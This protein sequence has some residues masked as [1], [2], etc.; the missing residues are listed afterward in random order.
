MHIRLNDNVEI[1][2]GAD[3][4]TWG[5]VLKILKEKRRVVV[6]GINRVR[7]HVQRSQKNPR[8]GQL[9]KEM[10]VDVSNVMY[11]CPHTSQP[12]RIGYYFDPEG[13]KHRY[14]RRQAVELVAKGIDLKEAKVQAVIDEVSPAKKSPESSKA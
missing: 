9:S 5:R 8:G 13:A 14:S 4:G 10:P 2:A 12:T 6:E 7:K 11:I 1:M 3:K